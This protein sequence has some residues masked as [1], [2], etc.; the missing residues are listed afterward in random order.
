[1]SYIGSSYYVPIFST[2]RGDVPLTPESGAMEAAHVHDLYYD[3]ANK[4]NDHLSPY[5]AWH[6]DPLER[7]IHQSPDV[8]VF[9]WDNFDP[10]WFVGIDTSHALSGAYQHALQTYGDALQPNGWDRREPWL[11]YDY[12]A[13]LAP[14]GMSHIPR[15]TSFFQGVYHT[16]FDSLGELQRQVHHNNFYTMCL[17]AYAYIINAVKMNHFHNLAY[18]GYMRGS[19]GFVSA[20]RHWC[21]TVGYPVTD[22]SRR[23][24]YG[25]FGFTDLELLREE[26]QE[27]ADALVISSPPAALPPMEEEAAE[28]PASSDRAFSAADW[29]VGAFRRSFNNAAENACTQ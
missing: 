21:R 17:T 26:Q 18:A 25:G 5:S 20:H 12:Q 11:D 6:P 3:Y 7:R 22:R 19:P 16:P 14:L 10:Q 4:H 13:Q 23:R 28:L 27:S 8:E 1:M 29:Q 2:Y 15:P 24:I 9:T